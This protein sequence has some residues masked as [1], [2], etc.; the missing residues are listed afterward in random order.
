MA[1]INLLLRGEQTRSVELGEDARGNLVRIENALNEI[2]AYTEY[3]RKQLEL[4]HLQ[5]EETKE[6]IKQPFLQAEELAIKSARLAELDALLNMDSS[7]STEEKS[8]KPSV[9][10]S[11]ERGS[12][13]MQKDAQQR[14]SDRPLDAAL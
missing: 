8:E 3:I 12:S 13:G 4:L 5:M 2:P 11:L 7:V 10:A 6:A 14:R 9:L 1:K